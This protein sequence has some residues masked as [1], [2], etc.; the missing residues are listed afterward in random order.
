VIKRNAL[1][2]LLFVKGDIVKK[3][4]MKK[5]ASILAGATG[6]V[7]A[8]VVIANA[9]QS[10]TAPCLNTITPPPSITACLVN[11]TPASAA[12]TNPK[13]VA[14]T[15]TTVTIRSTQFARTTL[16]PS[17][18]L[19]SSFQTL[20]TV[21]WTGPQN[22]TGTATAGPGATIT[23]PA[24]ITSLKWSVAAS[25]SVQK[26]LSYVGATSGTSIIETLVGT[27]SIIVP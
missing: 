27:P 2:L 15:A 9:Q 1:A 4:S 21:T 10:F 11:C 18:P 19:F 26:Q 8:L 6:W 5:V 14:A 23:V 25:S 17:D 3:P 12:S 13:G 24:G 20:Y 22:G 16:K 7:V